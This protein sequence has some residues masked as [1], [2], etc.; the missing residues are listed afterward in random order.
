[1][2][3]FNSFSNAWVDE[4]LPHHQTSAYDPLGRAY[5]IKADGNARLIS[6]QLV[7]LDVCCIGGY[8]IR[9]TRT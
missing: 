8:A 5:I 7:E 1:M 4:P 3:Q 9:F 6:T 2:T